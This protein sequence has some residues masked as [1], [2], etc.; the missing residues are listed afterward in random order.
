MSM[1]DI[2]DDN[3]I[4]KK[5]VFNFSL[6]HK[7][8][9][10]LT[11]SNLYNNNYNNNCLFYILLIQLFAFLLTMEIFKPRLFSS[12][13]TQLHTRLTEFLLTFSR[14]IFHTYIISEYNASVRFST[15][16]LTSVMLCES[17]LYVTGET[18]SLKSTPNDRF[19]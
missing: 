14:F 8:F 13:A 11:I 7:L 15:Q 10:G 1:K 12:H 4:R 3:A 18:Y 17:T 9:M 6:L 19:F 16:L 2:D 5:Y